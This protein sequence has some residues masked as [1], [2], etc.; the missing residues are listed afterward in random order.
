M[1]TVWY[2]PEG[3]AS[4][5]LLSLHGKVLVHDNPREME[6]LLANVK[7]KRLGTDLDRALAGRPHMLLR[8][9]PDMTWVRWPLRE[10][11]FWMTGRITEAPIRNRRWR[12][13]GRSS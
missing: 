11:D 13:H 4:H 8:D 10:E 6:F 12:R 7:I 9:H 2:A 1:T 3:L 5:E